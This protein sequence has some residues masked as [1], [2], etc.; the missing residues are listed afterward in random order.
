MALFLSCG[1]KEDSPS[2]DSSDKAEG[3]ECYPTEYNV[4]SMDYGQR[5][6][7]DADYKIIREEVFDEGES[8]G[9]LEYKYDGSGK[10]VRANYHEDN[11]VLSSYRAYTYNSSNL[12]TGIDEMNVRDG[13][14]VRGA[15]FFRYSYDPSG[16]LSREA[17]YM[18]F[19]GV[20]KLHTEYIYEYGTQEQVN[21]IRQVYH[22]NPTGV[23][24]ESSTRYFYENGLVVK[25]EHVSSSGR[26]TYTNYKYGEQ[27]SAT[28]ALIRKHKILVSFPFP[29]P[30]DMMDKVLLEASYTDESNQVADGEETYIN[31]YEFNEHNYPVKVTTKKHNGDIN[32][33]TYKYECT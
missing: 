12:L 7:Y 5:F 19:N 16:R 30:T 17:V 11:G 28:S 4:N 15:S 9:Y 8:L 3:K 23:P 25:Q 31:S 27:R 22:G 18:S 1:S 10:P 21:K 26:K 29:R 13:K 33:T 32:T 6:T 2:P 24:S 20:E 14:D